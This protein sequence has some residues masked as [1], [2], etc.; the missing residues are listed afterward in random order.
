MSSF[1]HTCGGR[2]CDLS[3]HTWQVAWKFPQY[4][5]DEDEEDEDEE[6]GGQPLVA[7]LIDP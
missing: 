1:C 7:S 5:E 3:P 6:G 2:P 4:E